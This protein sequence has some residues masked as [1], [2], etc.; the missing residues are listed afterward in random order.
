MAAPAKTVEKEVLS[1]A[2]LMNKATEALT[3]V[4]NSVNGIDDKVKNA[5]EAFDKKTAE[6][7]ALVAEKTAEING[8]TATFAEKERIGK[9]DVDLKLKQYGIQSA[10]ALL[11]DTHAVLTK[12][13][14]AD[15]K[16][17][18][19]EADAAI[20]KEVAMAKAA[21][22]SEYEGKLATQIADA[23]VAAATDTAKIA[24]LQAQVAFQ[25][26]QIATLEN[27]I[28]SER[29]AS[30]DRAKAATPVFNMP[31]SGK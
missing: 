27:M 31:S 13:Q 10:S 8:L 23:K 26:K 9:L 21:V 29:E 20:A 5:Q 17:K 30:V 7:D 18:S 6:F 22:K 4:V 15:L 25:E 14:Y 28:S 2:L 19:E 16:K 12:D 3:A 24:A 1:I 11:A